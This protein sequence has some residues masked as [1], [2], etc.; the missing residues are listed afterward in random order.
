M[1]LRH[2]AFK[3][4]V[5]LSLD[6]IMPAFDKIG[7]QSDKN[8][9]FHWTRSIGEHMLQVEYRVRVSSKE[10]SCFWIRWLNTKGDVDKGS[11]DR[12]LADWF[13]TMSQYGETTVYWMEVVLDLPS[14]RPLYGYNESSPKIWSKEDQVHRFSFF[15]V[16]DYYHFEVRN[17]KNIK[18]PIQHHR[19]SVW[20]DELNNNLLGHERPN[21]QIAFDMVG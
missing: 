7:F 20:L 2:I 1:K 8:K 17:K 3:W 4:S 13:F 12:I 10:R 9:R 5:V 15:P 6:G 21:D 18:N 11:L 14:F 19:F 16:L